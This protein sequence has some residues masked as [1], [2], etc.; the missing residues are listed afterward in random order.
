[1]IRGR[2]LSRRLVHGYLNVRTVTAVA[3]V[4]ALTVGTASAASVPGLGVGPVDPAVVGNPSLACGDTTTGL[5]SYPDRGI[6]LPKMS[7][8]VAESHPRVDFTTADVPMLRARAGGGAADPHGI[9]QR[10]WGQIST[11]VSNGTT[12][13]VSADDVNSRKAKA[14]GFAY[15]IT[16][17]TSDL[18]IAATA[19]SAAFVS[20]DS[21]DSYVAAQLT[22]YSQAYDYIAASLDPERDV[23]ARTAIKRG[24][25][26][27]ADWLNGEI[28]S[29]SN[30]RPHNH[31]SKVA[32]S[33]GLWSLVFSAD[34][35]AGDWL[36]LSV[37][38]INS[39]YQYMFT[40]DGIY[41]DGYAYY[42]IFQMF[43]ALPFF[44]AAKNVAGVDVFPSLKP[45]FEWMVR[46]SSPKGYLMNIED[47][48]IKLAWTSVVA[49]EYKSTHTDLSSRGSLA[50]VL[51]WRFFQQ[52][53]AAPQY[54]ANWTGA[55]NQAYL[56]PD[57]LIHIDQNI[58]EV[59]PDNGQFHTYLNGGSSSVMRSD[60]HYNDPA[61]RWIM[62]YG[63]PQSNNHDHCDVMEVL[64]NAENTTMLNDDG[65]GPTRFSGRADWF[66]SAQHNVITMN[67]AGSNDVFANQVSLG[68]D[69]T[70]YSEKLAYYDQSAPGVP[71]TKSWTRGVLFP[72]HDYAVIADS[73]HSPVEQTWDS[74][75]HSRGD[76]ARNGT[77][78]TWTTADNVF[79][80]SA[81]LYTYSLPVTATVAG[82]TGRDNLYGTGQVAPDTETNNY[83]QVTQQATDAQFLTFAVPRSTSAEPPTFADVSAGGVLAATVR[84]DGHTDTTLKQLASGPAHAGAVDTDARLA[85]T[86]QDAGAVRGWQVTDATRFSLNGVTQLKTSTPVTAT[87]DLLNTKRSVDI[88]ASGRYEIS[89]A[90]RYSTATFDGCRIYGKVSRGMTTYRLSGSGHLAL[91]LAR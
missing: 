52:D 68:G 67:G 47:S 23:A 16:G 56:W 72:A 20:F 31:R 81:G 9:Y 39:V 32:S 35:D 26:W 28:P 12:G 18:D 27:T 78:A 34:Q 50:N 51:Q 15:V 57:E 91:P 22:N 77:A 3:L 64:L 59:E 7:L 17:D 14:Y 66:G 40:R 37:D 80:P 43:H 70:D 75:L 90:G 38:E 13:G 41:L 79:G 49:T 63:A 55:L 88:Q 19:L 61:T 46:D 83:L 29:G 10:N 69:F 44:Y 54:P 24:A 62:F 76:L 33:L 11:D 73:L 25:Q 5:A 21:D 74:Y 65:Y 48:W 45:A 82:R 60:W 71:G 87:A 58:A 4:M 6:E 42:W 2:D 85:W 86:R 8:P 53:W 89:L 84:Y 1:M 36:T 30:P